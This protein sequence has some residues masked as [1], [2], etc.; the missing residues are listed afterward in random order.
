[1]SKCFECPYHINNNEFVIQ[2]I[3]LHSCV[4]LFLEAFSI[5]DTLAYYLQGRH[6]REEL[7]EL[8]Q[9]QKGFDVLT[10]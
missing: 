3:N 10:P 7:K 1:M 9:Y 4:H 8:D 5:L 2:P 6:A